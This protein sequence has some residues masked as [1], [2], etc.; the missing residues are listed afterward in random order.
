[1][2]GGIALRKAANRTNKNRAI[3]EHLTRQEFRSR[4]EA[5][6]TAVQRRY[7][8]AFGLWRAC[9]FKPCRRGRACSGDAAACLNRSVHGVPREAQFQARRALLRA[10]PRNLAA[11]ERA[12]R[13]MLP[14]E[15]LE[16][17][18]DT[19]SPPPGWTRSR[20]R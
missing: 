6:R 11:P 20:N 17:V 15:L 2:L 13:E 1:M 3:E 16:P 5:E 12:A 7:C 10:T 4:F 14:H 8:T 18:A 9:R 19:V